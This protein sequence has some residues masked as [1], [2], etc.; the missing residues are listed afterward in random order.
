MST[1]PQSREQ[2]CGNLYRQKPRHHAH[3]PTGMVSYPSGRRNEVNTARNNEN[4]VVCAGHYTI[5]ARPLSYSAGKQEK[6]IPVCW[7]RPNIAAAAP[8][9]TCKQEARALRQSVTRR[10]DAGE[11]IRDITVSLRVNYSQVNALELKARHEQGSDEHGPLFAYTARSNQAGADCLLLLPPAGCAARLVSQAYQQPAL[12]V[13]GRPPL[14]AQWSA[15]EGYHTPE[16]EAGGIY[17][18]VGNRRRHDSYNRVHRLTV[19]GLPP[20][21]PAIAR[22]PTACRRTSPG[23]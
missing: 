21:R 18:R 12:F 19:A 22:I 8:A 2:R 15:Y 16:R 4:P 11:T 23:D 13:P 9:P 3:P 14:D 10:L 17:A 1:R 7:L 5:T 6:G 20:S